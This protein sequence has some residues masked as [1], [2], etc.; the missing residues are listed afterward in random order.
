MRP[1]E[2]RIPIRVMT[3]DIDFAGIV[4][5]IVYIRWL[6]DLRIRMLDVHMPLVPM[7][8][9]GRMPIL[10]S[11]KID[12][13]RPIRIM[14]EVVGAMWVHDI[15]RSRWIM[16]AEFIANGEVTT[17]AEQS[18]VMVDMGTLRPV[19]LPEDLRQQFETEKQASGYLP[20]G[21]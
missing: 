14:D 3:Y 2:L 17:S 4:S 1:L 13:K 10:A 11:T 20:D 12:Y 6:E 18:G 8:Q 19:A 16:R 5:N 7:M 21:N 15:G 9:A